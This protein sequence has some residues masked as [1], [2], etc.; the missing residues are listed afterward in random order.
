MKGRKCSILL[1]KGNDVALCT[2]SRL[3]RLRKKQGYRHPA[4][5][6]HLNK[7]PSISR[8]F[9]RWRVT[10]VYCQTED[11]VKLEGDQYAPGSATNALS[12][13]NTL[14][15]LTTSTF[16]RLLNTSLNYVTIIIYREEQIRLIDFFVIF[17]NNLE[18]CG[19]RSAIGVD[20]VESQG[21]PGG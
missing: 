3:Y 1:S 13:C 17:E 15:Q 6:G 19:L 2:I 12:V 20:S 5:R 14:Y 8:L 16:I 21:R 7:V 11:I 9:L 10:D 18:Y 4:W